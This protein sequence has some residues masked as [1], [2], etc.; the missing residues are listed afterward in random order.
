MAGFF[1][2]G[3]FVQTPVVLSYCDS[4]SDQ[5]CKSANLPSAL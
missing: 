1:V 3:F 2:S 4:F 5:A